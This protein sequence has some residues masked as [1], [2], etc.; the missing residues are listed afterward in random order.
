MQTVHQ[1]LTVLFVLMSHSLFGV[2][3]I[4]VQSLLFLSVWCSLIDLVNGWRQETAPIMMLSVFLLFT[5]S[6]CHLLQCV[7]VMCVNQAQRGTDD[8]VLCSCTDTPICALV[9]AVFLFCCQ[10]Y[11]TQTQKLH[12]VC[13]HQLQWNK[14]KIPLEYYT[15]SSMGDFSKSHWPD[16]YSPVALRND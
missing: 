11:F 4:A 15:L 7:C 14:K 13:F 5:I 6:M 10:P 1:R 8:P 9:L 2:C 3:Q 12:S 16:F